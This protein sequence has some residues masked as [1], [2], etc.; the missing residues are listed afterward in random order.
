MDY[1]ILTPEVTTDPLARGYAG[2]SDQ[3]VADSL[4]AVDRPT[5]GVISSRALLAWSGLSQRLDNIDGAQNNPNQD[6]RT[7]AKVA[8]K[9]ID[10]SDTELDMADANHLAMVDALVADGVLSAADKTELLAMAGGLQSRAAEL[11]LTS[12][13]AGNITSARA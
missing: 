1:S 2:M 10:R 4:N 3:Q 5:T 9:L 7:I 6:V 11:G 12:V 13:S 8:L